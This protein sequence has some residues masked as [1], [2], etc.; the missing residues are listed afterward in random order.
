MIL[1]PRS[2]AVVEDA[3]EDEGSVSAR[4]VELSGEA[5]FEVVADAHL[6][7]LVQT[8][9]VTTRVLG[10]VFNVRRYKDIPSGVVSVQAGKVMVV[11]RTGSTVLTA[12]MSSAFTDSTILAGTR[13]EPDIYTDWAH[14]RLVFHEATVADVFAVLHRWY[15]YEFKLSDSTLVSQHVTG[16]F[17]I[18]ETAT[19][20]QLVK[21]VLGVD[22]TFQDSVVILHPDSNAQWQ[23]H[24]GSAGGASL[25]EFIHTSPEVGR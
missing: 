8:G 3:E 12:G 10:T 16:M 22:L 14:D 6:P 5:H 9:T 18:G 13:R 24:P 20:L 25:R 21:R 11:G 1:A 23:N 17:P 15:G 2:R 4:R 19:M 7:F